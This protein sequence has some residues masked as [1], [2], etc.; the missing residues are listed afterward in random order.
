MARQAYCHDGSSVLA[1][2]RVQYNALYLP[3]YLPAHLVYPSIVYRPVVILPFGQSLAN[4]ALQVPCQ[5][6]VS[7][8][9]ASIT[10]KMVDI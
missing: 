9:P 1:I 8:F 5:F 3:S 7:L 10:E 6:H 2:G 4:L